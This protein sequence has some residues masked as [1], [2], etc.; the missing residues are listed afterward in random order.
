MNRLTKPQRRILILICLGTL[1][2]EIIGVSHSFYFYGSFPNKIFGVP[3]FIPIAW[4]II[5]LFSYFISTKK[6]ILIGIVCGYLIDLA[7]E[8]MAFY[9]GAWTWASTGTP[10]IYFGS[11]I[12]NALVWVTVISISTV[13]LSKVGNVR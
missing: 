1:I 13:T 5:C 8:P 3:L 2:M 6:G 10:Q 11:T 4:S 7:L 9:S 12:G